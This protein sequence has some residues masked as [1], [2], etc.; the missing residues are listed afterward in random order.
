MEQITIECPNCKKKY[1]LPS[2]KL[3]KHDSIKLNCKNCGYSFF[4]SPSKEDNNFSKE[5][6][7]VIG[8]VFT[9][10]GDF[11]LAEFPKDCEIILTYKIKDAEVKKSVQ[12][13]LTIIGRTEGDIIINDPLISKKHAC[14]EVKSPTLILLKDLASKNGTFHNGMRV[15]SIHLQ[16]GDVIKVGNVEILFSSSIKFI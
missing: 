10:D 14:I 15:S 7:T 16:S 2:E 8:H 13:P 3:P 11:V 4:F 5:D 1:I 9:A 12:K 6:S